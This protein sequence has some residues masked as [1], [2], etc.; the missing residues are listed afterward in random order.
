MCIRDRELT[1][2]IGFDRMIREF[3]QKRHETDGAWCELYSWYKKNP[4]WQ[5]KVERF[6]EAG[7]YR[8]P[9]DALTEEAAKR[10]YGEEF[11]T[12]ITRMER[13]AVCAF[14]HFLTYG[15]GLREREEYDFQA[16]DLGNV[17]HRAL[18]RFSDVYKRQDI[19]DDA[20]GHFSST[21]SVETNEAGQKQTGREN[22]ILFPRRWPYTEHHQS[23]N[24]TYFRLIYI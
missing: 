10:L 23:G 15:L 19:G 6:L 5:E 17:C 7:Y 24:G 16:A 13:F 22:S 12:S 4:K 2:N 1:E 11:E 18:E 8:K 20:V 3:V 21:S 14:S 9:L